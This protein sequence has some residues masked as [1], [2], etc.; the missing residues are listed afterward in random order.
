MMTARINYNGKTFRGRTNSANGEVGAATQF[1]YH[2]TGQ[3]LTGTYR[4]GSVRAG[5]LLGVVHDDD[6]LTFQYHHLNESGELM[7]GRCESTPVILDGRLVMRERW[8][9]LTGDRSAGT[10]EVEEVTSK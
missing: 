8:Q 6:T 5:Q 9:W 2:Q 10:S 1:E 3:L 4:G 7:A